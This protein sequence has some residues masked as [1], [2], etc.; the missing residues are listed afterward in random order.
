M[1]PTARIAI[2]GL[3]PLAMLLAN[4]LVRA[5]SNA[6]A[7]PAFEVAS[8]RRSNPNSGAGAGKSADGNGRSGPPLQ[9]DHR[10]F[11][12]TSSLFGF[13]IRAYGV[14]EC[15]AEGDAKCARLSGGPDW[16]MKDQFEIQA[17]IPD[18]S[19]DYT[20]T[21]FGAG[22]APQLQSMLQ[23]LLAERFN[24]KIHREKRQLAVY[25]LAVAKSGP[26]LK[27]TAGEMIQLNDG[28]LV[29]KRTLFFDR[30]NEHT[31]QLIVV[32]RSIQ[33]LADALSRMRDRPVLN[34]T[35]LQGEFDFTIEYDRDPDEPGIAGSLGPTMFAAFQE[36]LGLKFE[37]TKG[38]VEAIVIDHAERPSEN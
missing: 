25:E 22:Q 30:V 7:G 14:Q 38:P 17:K 37:S 20:V 8:V 9:I 4:S 33:E 35:E 18:D 29:K 28:S 16:L 19:P 24:L 15:L 11:Y 1:L 2:A 32:D 6:P 31:I 21:Q 3:I 36:Q 5:Q 13:I 23:A 27:K 12:Y 10:R 26:K 34:R